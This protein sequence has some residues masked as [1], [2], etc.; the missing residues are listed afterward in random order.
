MKKRLRSVLQTALIVALLVGGYVIGSRLHARTFAS[1]STPPVEFAGHIR[2]LP[3]G[4]FGAWRVDDQTVLVTRKTTLDTVNGTPAEGV[5][6]HVRAHEEGDHLVADVVRVL[7]AREDISTFS[8]H[9]LVQEVGEGYWVVNGRRIQVDRHTRISGTSQ[10][11]PGQVA[12][13][14]GHRE[15]DAYVADE[16]DLS[17]VEEEATLVEFTGVVEEVRGATWVV[18]GLEIPA[19]PGEAPPEPGTL[20]RIRGHLQGPNK[21]IPT[22]LSLQP[23]D[24]QLTG[25]LLRREQR[26]DEQR[27]DLLVEEGASPGQ[28]IAVRIRPDTPVDER[29]GTVQAGAR[30][31][32]YGERKDDSS[33]EATFARVLE[34]RYTFLIGTLVYIPEGDLYAYPWTVNDTQV[35]VRPNTISDQPHDT[36]RVG[37]RVAVSGVYK[38][39]GTLIA[40][41][42]SHS[43]R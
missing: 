10:V 38:D 32:V 43:K 11:V 9:G 5:P 25:W 24:V 16:I 14:R 33:V 7:P 37:D 19:P 41:M 30:V 23:P 4:I 31:T 6:V 40:H 2:S 35:W 34:T 3:S 1:D 20:V 39:D 42:I 27:W 13:V 17:T 26:A 18:N 21:L 22:Y 29:E 36:F 12:T 28:E 15:G 8:L